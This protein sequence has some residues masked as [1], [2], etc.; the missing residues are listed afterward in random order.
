MT[1]AGTTQTT[2]K[3]VWPTLHDYL[4]P[5]HLKPP[6]ESEIMHT[7]P[8]SAALPV[9]PAAGRHRA[10]PIRRQD[11]A[12]AG[13]QEAARAA[14]GTRRLLAA[15]GS[16]GPLLFLGLATLAGAL[17]PGYNPVNQTISEIPLGPVGWLQTANF[18]VFG[19]AV[20]T[21]GL[22]LVLR[23]GR[24]A[25]TIASACLLTL[26]GLSLIA[27]GAFPA[28]VVDGEPTPSAFIHGLAF[29]GTFVPL[30]GAYAFAALRLAE[31]TGWRRFATYTA[32]LPS[33][34][35]FLLV[36]FGVLGTDPGAP[37]LFISGLLN[38]LLL[39][40]AFTW[41][42]LLGC[43]LLTSDVAACLSSGA[44]RTNAPETKDMSHDAHL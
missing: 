13:P 29:F 28:I 26:S 10:G 40:V 31:D 17:T 33:S 39:L 9:A 4:K 25:R 23:F 24:D 5:A 3:R 27:A 35:V 11:H 18:Y 21:F 42:S 2:R 19:A 36:V 43:R 41:I 6:P 20:A 8:D 15:L 30:P 44:S 16:T 14:L 1:S 37:L 32:A 34:M 38:R 22:A 7:H 12:A